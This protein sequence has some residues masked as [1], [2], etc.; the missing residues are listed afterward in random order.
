MKMFLNKGWIV[1]IEGEEI[2]TLFGAKEKRKLVSFSVC[3]EM[4]QLLLIDI[5]FAGCI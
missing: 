5:V 1:G 2:S 4:P 3:V